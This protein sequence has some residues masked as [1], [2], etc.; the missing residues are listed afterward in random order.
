MGKSVCASLGPNVYVGQILAHTETYVKR[1]KKE[2]ESSRYILGDSLSLA[3]L[4]ISNSVDEILHG[5]RSIRVLPGVR[6]VMDRQFPILMQTYQ[7]VK[8]DM[9]DYLRER[10]GKFTSKEGLE[11]VQ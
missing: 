4:A 1:I 5:P 2:Q 6:S 11:D 7:V 3:D 9:A 8:D 10:V